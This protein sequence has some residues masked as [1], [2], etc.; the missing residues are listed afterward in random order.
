MSVF[1][2]SHRVAS[3]LW[4]KSHFVTPKSPREANFQK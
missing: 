3:Q 4:L 2:K 1:L